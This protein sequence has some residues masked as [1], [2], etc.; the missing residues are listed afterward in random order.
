MSASAS[1][2][3]ASTALGNDSNRARQLLLDGADVGHDFNAAV[4]NA[5]RGGHTDVLKLVMVA[6]E[7]MLAA[8]DDARRSAMIGGHQHIDDMLAGI[9][10]GVAPL[11][12]KMQQ[13]FA[14]AVKTGDKQKASILLDQM[15]T[16]VFTP[17]P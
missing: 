14:T 10:P 2:A 5:A 3:L 8:R 9:D 17:K 15:L 12:R 16:L 11:Q 1:D 13:E 4:Q 7:I 6:D